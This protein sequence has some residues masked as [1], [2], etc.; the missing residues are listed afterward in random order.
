MRKNS[1]NAQL[2]QSKLEEARRKN[3]EKQRK[4]RE[5]GHAAQAFK[6]RYALLKSK[7]LC[8]RCGKEDADKGRVLCWRCRLNDR[9]RRIGVKIEGQDTEGWARKREKARQQMLKFHARRKV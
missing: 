1:I 8:V 2:W 7:G 6:E 4:Y 3:R 9:D 5:S